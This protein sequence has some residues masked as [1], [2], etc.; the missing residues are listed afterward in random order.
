MIEYLI[1]WDELG[2]GITNPSNP[3]LQFSAVKKM[4]K[5]PSKHMNKLLEFAH[6]RTPPD[7]EMIAAQ[8]IAEAD[9]LIAFLSKLVKH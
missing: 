6:Y 4:T 3:F 9:Y 5:D 7:R 1:K 8:N 2:L